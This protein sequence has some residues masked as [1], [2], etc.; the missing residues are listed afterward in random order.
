M[1][2]ARHL[3]VLMYHH[4]S[5]NP[6]LV[7][8]SLRT[9]RE[10]MQWLAENGW[11]TVSAAEMEFFY[12]GGKLPRKSVMLTFDDGYLD[13]WFY[14][15]PVLQAF[16]LRAHIFLVTGLIG[17]GP[18]RQHEES[19]GRHMFSHRECETLIAQG[20]ADDVMLRWSEVREMSRSGL[21]EFH[22][23]TH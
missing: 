11:K 12:C 13:N 2:D 22:L 3:P 20:R 8:L 5:N 21:V 9:F 14:A 1:A 4:I 16:G 6:G 15:F 23:H 19:G 17:D 18:A 7:T 10:Q